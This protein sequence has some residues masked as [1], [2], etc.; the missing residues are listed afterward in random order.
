V[1]E[2]INKV[3]K[4]IE[5]SKSS[6]EA[7]DFDL[8]RYRKMVAHLKDFAAKGKL[9]EEDHNLFT[10]INSYISPDYYGNIIIPNFK[11]GGIISAQKG[12]ILQQIVEDNKKYAKQVPQTSDGQDYSQYVDSNKKTPKQQIDTS[13]T[14]GKMNTLQAISLAGSIGSF[15]PGFGAIGGAVST[16][17]DAVDG[18]QDGWDKQD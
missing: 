1:K 18:A 6:G 13:D 2:E 12:S 4:I 3:H 10:T 17:A 9:S 11:I 8:D 5:D 15:I 7:P 14:V 16:V